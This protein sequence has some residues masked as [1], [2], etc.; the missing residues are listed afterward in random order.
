MDGDCLRISIS[1]SRSWKRIIE[2]QHDEIVVEVEPEQ[3]ERYADG[4]SAKDRARL[5]AASPAIRRLPARKK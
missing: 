2:E 1:L 4:P 5:T 3:R